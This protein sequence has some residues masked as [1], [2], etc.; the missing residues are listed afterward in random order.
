MKKSL[1]S[2]VVLLLIS[3]SASAV[4]LCD[5]NPAPFRGGPNT[6]LQTWTFS[7]QTVPGPGN[8]IFPD[9]WENPYGMP[10]VTLVGDFIDNTIWLPEDNGHQG[11]WI[12]D[13]SIRSNMIARIEND[14]TQRPDKNIW[15]QIT[16]S[17]QGG[18]APMLYVIPNGVTSAYQPLALVGTPNALGDGY[19]TAAYSL[20][21]HPNP[22][23]EQIYIRP[24]DCQ[25]FVDCITIETQCIPEPMT[26]GLLGLGS[27]LLRRRIA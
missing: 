21:I 20:T 23:W 22:A 24:R 10:E 2:L 3:A 9:V 15:V 16:Y 7:T 5:P 19:F 25:V 1:A 27:L 18:A 14:K 12:V 11:V 6:T 26:M 4:V 17:S 8:P 13:Q